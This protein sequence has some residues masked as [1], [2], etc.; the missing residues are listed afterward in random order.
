MK[1]QDIQR[2]IIKYLI[3][4]GAYVV[5]IVVA[6]RAGVPDIIC[7][8]DGRL[9]GIE[10]KKKGGVVSALQK[11]HIKQINDAGGL[12]LVAYSVDDVKNAIQGEICSQN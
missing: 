9:V 3:S 5:K 4:I 1:E 7:C 2:G 11:Y 10:V 12:A 6:N 8:V